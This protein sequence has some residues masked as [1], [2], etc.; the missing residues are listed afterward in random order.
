M[1]GKNTDVAS[2]GEGAGTGGSRQRRDMLLSIQ[3][4][5][6]K[7]WYSNKV[8]ETNVDDKREKYM[9]TFPYPYMNGRLHLGHAFTFTKAD[10]QARFQRMN[11]KNVLFPFGF[12]C[13][14][15]PIC[16]SADKLKM[17]L[18]S[19]GS[20]TQQEDD[21]Y[22][23]PSNHALKSK[24]VAKT[25][26]MKKQ[27]DILRSMG[28]KEEEIARFTD[29]VYWTEYFPPLAMRDLKDF[30]A[31]VDWRRSFITTDINPYYDS[32]IKWQFRTLKVSFHFWK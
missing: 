5:M 27:G 28:I 24:V 6:Q 32:F 2:P 22:N 8:Y 15:M 16:A 18:S 3:N 12:H 14:G 1:S 9:V 25:G 21:K 31:A 11:N 10:F 13:T 4:D 23:D 19:N 17:E 30:G 26:G 20:G 7:L 29:P